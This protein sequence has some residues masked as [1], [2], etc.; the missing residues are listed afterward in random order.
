M[1]IYLQHNIQYIGL[2]EVLIKMRINK[3]PILAHL[4][5]EPVKKEKKSVE[6]FTLWGRVIA[7]F[8]YE[9]SPIRRNLH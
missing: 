3:S 1:I 2:Q 6:N 8:G 5:R 4:I 7:L 9:S